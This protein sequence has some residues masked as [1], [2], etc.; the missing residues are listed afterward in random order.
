[1]LRSFVRVGLFGLLV[2]GQP[3]I[4]H[5]AIVDLIPVKDTYIQQGTPPTG[6]S[7]TNFGNAAEMVI[8]GG[9]GTS[10]TIRKGYMQFDVSSLVPSQISSAALELEV[11]LQN[12]GGGSA[13]YTYNVEVWGLN[14]GSNEAWIEGTGQTGVTGATP[15]SPLVWNNA[16]ANL[17]ANLFDTSL[18]T[19]LGNF[20]ISVTADNQ[21]VGQ[22]YGINSTTSPGLLSFLQ[23]DTDGLVTLMLRRVDASG[24]N[25]LSF[26]SL[27]HATRA[28]PTLSVEAIPEP[29]SILFCTGLLGVGMWMVRRRAS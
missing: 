25:N 4:A 22:L 17:N 15:P 16:P 6:P 1:M 10:A 29:S 28:A 7:Q 9:T 27:N 18:A 11:N 23:D 8:K 19:L 24:S 12:S 2:L 14:D 5:A 13:S 3:L 20:T 26:A 21:T